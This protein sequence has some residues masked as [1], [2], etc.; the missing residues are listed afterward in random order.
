MVG[1]E[2]CTVSDSLVWITHPQGHLHPFRLGLYNDAIE[3]VDAI[4]A[5][6]LV[7]EVVHWYVTILSSL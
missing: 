6:R 3:Y 5:F 1:S 4:G 7:K 2:T